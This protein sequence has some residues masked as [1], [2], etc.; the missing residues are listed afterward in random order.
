[1]LVARH[2]WENSR[3]VGL[4]EFLDAY[5]PQPGEQDLRGWE[6]YYLKALCNKSL[7]TL[8]GHTG[9]VRS[10]AWS[11]DGRHIASAGD[12]HT[13]RIWDWLNAKQVFVLNDHTAQ[14]RSVAW[15]PDGQRLASAGD[16]KTVKIWDWTN[17]K[18]VL[19]LTGHEDLV[20]SVTWSPDG[21]RLASGSFDFT[22]K[23]WD[24]SLGYELESG[25][26]VQATRHVLM[27]A[28]TRAQTIKPHSTDRADID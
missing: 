2:N 16:D 27:Q 15:S 3:V 22:V 25:P 21:R 5:R 26:P 17:R 23:I 28:R 10:V 18:V 4:Q 20:N 11:P 12:D 14:V 7:L 13:V 8:N 1:M 19:T 6:W 9:A 24:A